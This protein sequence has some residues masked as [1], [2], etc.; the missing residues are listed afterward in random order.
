MWCKWD[1][2]EK[3]G[4]GDTEVI[5]FFGITEC[6]IMVKTDAVPQQDI[7]YMGLS[8]TE[9][10]FT[11]GALTWKKIPEVRDYLKECIIFGEHF[12]D[13]ILSLY[14]WK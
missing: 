9:R 6:G 7:V 10:K 4:S 1:R 3:K 5:C 12:K 14:A 8:W 11:P 13:W 2:A